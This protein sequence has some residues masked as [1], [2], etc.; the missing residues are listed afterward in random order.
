MTIDRKTLDTLKA[1]KI[2]LVASVE[3]PWGGITVD[4]DPGDVDDF[5]RDRAEWFARKN[6]AFKSQY[7]DWI[8]TYGE[9]RC[10][11]TTA[12]GTRCQNSVSGGIQRPF[13]VW[14]QEDGGFCHA[15][16]GLTSAEA[17]SR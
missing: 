10:G 17:R 3:A 6:G 16:G 14:L 7:Q 11:A 5:I 4:L 13:D 8:A 1:A 15:H 9:P 2:N 12:K